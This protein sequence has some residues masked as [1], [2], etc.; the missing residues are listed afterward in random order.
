[1]CGWIILLI[2]GVIDAIV[3]ISLAANSPMGIDY[4]CYMSAIL[5]AMLAFVAFINIL[6]EVFGHGRARY[7]KKINNIS[8]KYSGGRY[9]NDGDDSD[10]DSI[11]DE[12]RAQQMAWDEKRMEE[13]GESLVGYVVKDI[14]RSIPGFGDAF[15]DDDEE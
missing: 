6:K 11:T 5:G 2:F 12:M 10:Y 8:D 4:L 9:E 7:S 3:S 15:E 13:K 14:I 1:M